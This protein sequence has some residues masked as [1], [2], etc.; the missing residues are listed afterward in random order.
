MVGLKVGFT[1]LGLNHLIGDPVGGGLGFEEGF[2]VTIG[3]WDG[4]TVGG[5]LGLNVGLKV[6]SRLLGIGEGGDEGGFS[7]RLSKIAV[8]S[9]RKS[10]HVRRSC[11]AKRRRGWA[12]PLNR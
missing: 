4:L 7:F 9:K 11:R 2:L 8:H 5:I 6:G 1:M 12:Q 10:K 3:D